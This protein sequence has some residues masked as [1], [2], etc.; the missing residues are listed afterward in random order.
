MHKVKDDLVLTTDE[1]MQ[2]LRVSKPTLLKQIRLGKLRATKVGREWRFLQSELY[3]LL[4]AKWQ[5]AD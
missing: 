2:Y 3:R 5:E 1:A 4:R